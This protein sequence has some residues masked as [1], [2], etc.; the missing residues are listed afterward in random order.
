M[1]LAT[2]DRPRMLHV[3]RVEPREK[4]AIHPLRQ[5]VAQKKVCRSFF[6]AW[7][8]LSSGIPWSKTNASCTAHTLSAF[9]APSRTRHKTNAL[10][11]QWRRAAFWTA[12]DS[13][14]RQ[15]EESF[16]SFQYGPGVRPKCDLESLDQKSTGH[17][18][19][20][21]PCASEFRRGVVPPRP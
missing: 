9:P 20:P 15:L 18:I 14:P 11:L 16:A 7:A 3:F 17:V 10:E 19:V 5:N 21:R 6:D 2:I 8:N 1:F 13:P 12:C 4:K